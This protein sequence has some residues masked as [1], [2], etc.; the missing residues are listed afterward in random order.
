MTATHVTE[1]SV[2]RE[3]VYAIESPASEEAGAPATEQVHVS[4]LVDGEL[5]E[6]REGEVV[7]YR[8][9]QT[10]GE[11]SNAQQVCGVGTHARRLLDQPR[12]EVAGEDGI[13]SERVI[14]TERNLAGQCEREVEVERI[15]EGGVERQTTVREVEYDT[16]TGRAVFDEMRAVEPE[17]ARGYVADVE[18][19]GLIT[20]AAAVA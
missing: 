20:P 9:P 13:R 4:E 16:Q 2:P 6:T 14:I 12:V 3:Q 15:L 19:R 11:Q 1:K 5:C 7:A 8:S 10:H 18:E 17:R